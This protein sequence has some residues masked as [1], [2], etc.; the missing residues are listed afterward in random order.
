MFDSALNLKPELSF[1]QAFREGHFSW[2]KAWQFACRE[3]FAYQL[4]CYKDS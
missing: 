3:W 4:L 1:I 2:L